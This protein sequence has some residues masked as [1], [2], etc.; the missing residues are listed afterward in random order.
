MDLY[1]SA[2]LRWNKIPDIGFDRAKSALEK[3]LSHSTQEYSLTEFLGTNCEHYH[4]C[5]RSPV[6]TKFFLYKCKI[7]RSMWANASAYDEQEYIFEIDFWP[8]NRKKLKPMN[9]A[10]FF[11]FYEF[12]GFPTKIVRPIS[13]QGNDIDGW[14]F[15]HKYNFSSS[16]R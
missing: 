15:Y 13:A 7:R 11:V 10:N 12:S 2:F 16:K 6:C 1:I 4:F 3:P 8:Y 9:F 14:F 5:Q